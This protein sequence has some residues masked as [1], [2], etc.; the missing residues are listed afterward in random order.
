MLFFS[1]AKQPYN[2]LHLYSNNSEDKPNE[3]QLSVCILRSSGGNAPFYTY[4]LLSELYSTED[5]ELFS[6]EHQDIQA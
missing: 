6:T 1:G 4:R 2:T 5:Q 3:K